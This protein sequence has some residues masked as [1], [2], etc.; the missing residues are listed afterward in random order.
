MINQFSKEFRDDAVRMAAE[1][2]AR[3]NVT[4]NAAFKAVSGLVKCS[5][6]SLERWYKAQERG[7]LSERTF[8][9]Q[10]LV[11]QLGLTSR[12]LRFYEEV[13]LVRPERRGQTRRFSMS[14]RQAIQ[15]IIHLR[16]LGFSLTEIQREG[17]DLASDPARLKARQDKLIERQKVLERSSSRVR[18]ALAEIADD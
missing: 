11:A 14:D 10:E 12:S 16:E 2:Q 7:L 3:H 15:K 5:P 6:K 18:Q 4:L 17:L 8:S 13:G 1:Y 9:M